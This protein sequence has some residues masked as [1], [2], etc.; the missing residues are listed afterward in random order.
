MSYIP[1]LRLLGGE[2]NGD[3][4]IVIVHGSL[5]SCCEMVNLAKAL[6]QYGGFDTVYGFD[7]WSY[8]GA[9]TE[10]PRFKIKD[11]LKILGPWG[12]AVGTLWKLKEFL[13]TPSWAVEGA[14]Q[15]LAQIIS[16]RKWKNI[17]LIGHS[18][19]GLV[20]RCTVEAHPIDECVRS[21]VT[22]GSPHRL[23][24]LT[25]HPEDWTG[26]PNRA[27]QYLIMLG[28]RDFVSPYRDLGDLTKN[29]TKYPN[30][31]KILY[32][33]LDHR[34]IHAKAEQTWVPELIGAFN[35]GRGRIPKKF[36]YI[37]SDDD[38]FPY[39]Y[40]SEESGGPGRETSR[41]DEWTGWL[42]VKL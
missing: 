9:I 33:G 8:Y 41:I 28:S 31:V 36:A 37:K 12:I 19:G 34:S 14:A 16:L 13:S 15:E 2:E 32:P 23:W 42:E 39:V 18:L 6:V 35:K 24:H 27:M 21:V 38:G 1:S 4:K 5:S 10:R 22:L 29:D 20:V 11:I 30:I 40:I 26:K 7:S 3:R 25:H 17:C